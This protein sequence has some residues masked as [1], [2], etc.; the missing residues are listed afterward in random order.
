MRRPQAE[1]DNQ[2]QIIARIDRLQRLIER[3]SVA[4]PTTQQ[5]KQ[6]DEWL[7]QLRQAYD[8][9]A[10]FTEQLEKKYGPV[11]GQ[12]FPRDQIQKS[13][14]AD[15]AFVA[16]LD[17]AGQAKAADPN[18]EHWA[19]L[20]RSAGPPVWIRLPGSGEKNAWTDDDTQLPSKLLA[21]LHR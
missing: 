1:R 8:E 9:L 6:R 20:L 4:K 17:I 11:A 10:E 19:I 7:G 13:L 14:P 5:T 21:A 12:V 2:S 15:A 3:I 18:G 16:W